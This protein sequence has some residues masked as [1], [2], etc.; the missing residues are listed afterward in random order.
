MIVQD[1][2]A[3]VSTCKSWIRGSG[4]R[5]SPRTSPASVDRRTFRE[6]LAAGLDG[7]IAFGHEL[8]GYDVD[9]GGVLLHFAGRQIRR[10]GR[11]G[12]RGRHRLR[13]APPVPARRF[14]RRQ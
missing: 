2:A 4:G 8:T 14:T 7:R 11:A 5:H 3:T 13:G 10:G 9:A 6:V 12:R 1:P